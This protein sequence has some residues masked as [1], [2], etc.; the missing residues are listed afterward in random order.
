[1]MRGLWKWCGESKPYPPHGS[2]VWFIY[3][4]FLSTKGE[5]H[6]ILK[7]FFLFCSWV[8]EIEPFNFLPF[9][10]FLLGHEYG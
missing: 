9:L 8:F 4:V 10:T 1:M 6:R 2:L 5:V 3:H 7:F